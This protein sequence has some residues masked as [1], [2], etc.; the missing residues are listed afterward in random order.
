M[1]SSGEESWETEEEEDVSDAEGSQDEEKVRSVPYLL[2]SVVEVKISL[3]II[4]HKPKTTQ[5]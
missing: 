2:S 4:Q 3:F 1:N 5:I